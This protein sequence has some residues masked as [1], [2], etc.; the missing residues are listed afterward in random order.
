[1]RKQKALIS[2]LRGLVD[3]LTKE[4]ARNPEFADK[5]E[6][7]LSDLPEPK[8]VPKRSVTKSSAGKLPDIHAEWHTRGEADFRLWLHGQPVAVL[9]AV[10]RAQDFD[11]TRRTSKWKEAEKLAEFIVDS[12][13]A[14]ILRGASFIGR[15]TVE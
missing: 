7:L 3:F 6:A 8:V 1:M 11:A 14:R 2:L 5:L 13:R 4:S 12:L 9:R 15:G 10:I